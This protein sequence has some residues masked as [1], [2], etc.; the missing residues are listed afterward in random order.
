MVADTLGDLLPNF[1]ECSVSN[2][3]LPDFPLA[4]GR[5]VAKISEDRI[6]DEVGVISSSYSFEPDV[7]SIEESDVKRSVAQQTEDLLISGPR[8][9]CK[10]SICKFESKL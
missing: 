10:C 5:K 4:A 3:T 7:D 9:S 8:N 2:D 6:E 1:K